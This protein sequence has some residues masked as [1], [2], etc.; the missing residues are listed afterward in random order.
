[1]FNKHSLVNTK[2]KILRV[3]LIWLFGFGRLCLV[4]LFFSI[5]L[6]Y[7]EPSGI[8]LVEVYQCVP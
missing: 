6:F 7:S 8:L 5:I 1:M 3:G 4:L 2:E